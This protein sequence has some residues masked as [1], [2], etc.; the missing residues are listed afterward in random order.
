MLEGE[1]LTHLAA[2]GELRTFRHEGFW[3]PMDTLRD[4]RVL[5]AAWESGKAPWKVWD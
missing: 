5:E 1:P 4:K 3:K 2:A